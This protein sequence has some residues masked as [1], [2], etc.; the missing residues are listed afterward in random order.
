MKTSEEIAQTLMDSVNLKDYQSSTGSEV[1]ELLTQ[2]VNEARKGM[3]PTPAPSGDETHSYVFRA[4]GGTTVAWFE[5]HQHA[6][7]YSARMN[8]EHGKGTH[9][10]AHT[11]IRPA[12][13]F[14]W[15]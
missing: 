7:A 2:A 9:D 11:F 13:Q 14:D 6:R 1:R 12:E 10:W 3:T 15:S 5:D 8:K 4:E